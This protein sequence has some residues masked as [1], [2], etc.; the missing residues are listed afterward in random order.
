[1]KEVVEYIDLKWVQ[2]REVI[3][4]MMVKAFLGIQVEVMVVKTPPQDHY[5]GRNSHP[6]LIVLKAFQV[7]PVAVRMEMVLMVV[8]S[9][10]YHTVLMIL[11]KEVIISYRVL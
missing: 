9:P 11:E 1:M 4:H 8:I 3:L 5:S 7:S 6:F 2:N 10:N